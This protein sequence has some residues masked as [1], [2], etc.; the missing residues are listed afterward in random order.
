MRFADDSRNRPKTLDELAF[1][2]RRVAQEAC[3]LAR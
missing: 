2:V 1:L 3:G